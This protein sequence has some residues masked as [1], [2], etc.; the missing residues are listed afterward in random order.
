M[1]ELSRRAPDPGWR[2][3][4]LSLAAWAAWA[5]GRTA[6]A[7]CAVDRALA[8][9]SAY[10]FALLIRAGLHHGISSEAVRASADNTR[11]ALFEDE[12]RPSKDADGT[13]HSGPSGQSGPPMPVP[14]QRSQSV[15]EEARS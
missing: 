1:T 6:L 15:T 8:T 11:R 7:Q 14:A 4:P 9:D 12:L 5:L 2:T 13:E 10:H 3:T